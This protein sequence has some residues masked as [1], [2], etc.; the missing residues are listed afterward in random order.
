MS[1]YVEI[2]IEEMD[3]KLDWRWEKS[4]SGGEWIYE[5]KLKNGITIKVCSSIRTDTGYSRGNGRDAIRI[6]AYNRRTK[7][8]VR[9]GIRVNRMKNWREILEKKVMRLFNEL[10][11]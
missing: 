11:G 3:K 8:G 9:G 1:R 10:K 2:S 7:R 5:Y 6:C 4:R